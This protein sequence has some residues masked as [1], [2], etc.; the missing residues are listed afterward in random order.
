MGMAEENNEL[1][2]SNSKQRDNPKTVACIS[3]TTWRR[4]SSSTLKDLHL[5]LA[6]TCRWIFINYGSCSFGWVCSTW[7]GLDQNGAHRK[8]ATLL[9]GEGAN[10]KRIKTINV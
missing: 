9:E 4:S 3:Q 10:R 6:S 2:V 1:R 8:R 7:K 5:K